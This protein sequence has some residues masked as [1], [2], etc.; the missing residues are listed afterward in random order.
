MLYA[1]TVVVN[2]C[3][4]YLMSCTLAGFGADEARDIFN[5]VDLDG[6]G[7]VGLDEF[8]KWWMETQ[9][10]QA[11]YRPK[12]ELTVAA[13]VEMLTNMVALM[14]RKNMQFNADFFL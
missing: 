10:Q 4:A 13:L 7:S 1:I 3:V 8:E 14:K 2:C 12:A 5:Q 9:H 11:K 6:G